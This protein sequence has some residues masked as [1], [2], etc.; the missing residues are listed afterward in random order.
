MMYKGQRVTWEY[1]YNV[2][3]FDCKRLE[4]EAAI[5]DFAK[6]KLENVHVSN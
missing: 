2:F 3:K 5:P 4:N 1:I 6:L